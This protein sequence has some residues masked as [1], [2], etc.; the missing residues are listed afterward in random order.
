[1]CAIAFDTT[2]D[3]LLPMV[4]LEISNA[5]SEHIGST[6]AHL[7]ASQKTCVGDDED[8]LEEGGAEVLFDLFD[9]LRC[10][11]FL[12]DGLLPRRNAGKKKPGKRSVCNVPI[13]KRN[14]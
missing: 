12:F 10:R 8:S 2:T 6:V 1:M 14:I 7:R 3:A 13:V 9:R 5:V 11:D 4:A